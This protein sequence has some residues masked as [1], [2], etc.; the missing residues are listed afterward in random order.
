MKVLVTGATSGLGRNA[1][2]WLLDAGHQVHATGRDKPCRA[3]S[4]G[5]LGAEFSP[6]DLTQATAEQCRQLMVGLRLGMALRGKI[7]PLGQQAEFYQA[8]VV[9]TEKLARRQGRAACSAL[10]IFP[11]R[12]SISISTSS[13][14]LTKDIVPGASPTITPPVNMPPSSGCWGPV[15]RYPQTTYIILR[16][17]GLFGPHDRVIVPRLLQ[18][19]DRDR[20]VL[21]LPGGGKAGWI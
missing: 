2:Q 21:R 12:Q 3:R 6:L 13:R 19:L 18:Q 9:A 14:M 8:N 20:G 1:A 15:P 4:S 17:R 11:R 7:L 5:S 16:P 10:F